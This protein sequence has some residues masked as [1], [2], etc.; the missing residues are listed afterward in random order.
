[1]R[2]RDNARKI[3]YNWRLSGDTLYL[4]EYFSLP[5]GSRWNGS[6]VDIDVS[7]PEGTEVRCVPGTIALHMAPAE[8][9]SRSNRLAC[10]GWKPGGIGRLNRGNISAPA[11]FYSSLSR[12]EQPGF[13]CTAALNF[14]SLGHK[15]AGR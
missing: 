13:F 5:A 10:R 3:E 14:L 7:L 8:E 9:L 4:D 2:P 11:F 1:M 6:L 15:L 12:S